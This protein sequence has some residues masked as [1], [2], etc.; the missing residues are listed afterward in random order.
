MRARLFR[1]LRS[2]GGFTLL[3]LV[4][5]MAILGLIV[6]ILGA[7][8]RISQNAILTGRRSIERTHRA[9]VITERISQELRSAYL[10][11]QLWTSVDSV[12]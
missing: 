7:A 12:S 8:L 10:P 11:S 5:A 4:I 1:V 9:R 3:E 2:Q 6:A